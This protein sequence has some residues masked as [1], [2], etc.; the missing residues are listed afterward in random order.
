MSKV[1]CEICHNG[2]KGIEDKFLVEGGKM[3][4]SNCYERTKRGDPLNE[5]SVI[6]PAYFFDIQ[7][8]LSAEEITI[9]QELRKI[10]WGTLTVTKKDGKI[11]T[12]TPASIFRISE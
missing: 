1:S 11:T 5:Q 8:K 10:K 12:Y 3:I 7:N 9:I 2:F 4:C 6:K